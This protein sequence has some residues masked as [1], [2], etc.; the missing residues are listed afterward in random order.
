MANPI[1][2]IASRSCA[3]NSMLK[4]TG[5]T[6]DEKDLSKGRE[7][8]QVSTTADVPQDI[9][10]GRAA[11]GTQTDTTI[12]KPGSEGKPGSKLPSYKEAWEKD[13]EGIKSKYAS[14]EDYVKDMQGIKPGDARDVEREAA[15]AEAA[16]GTPGTPPTET[17]TSD[18]EIEQEQVKGQ[19]NL[20]LRADIRQ[21]KI[22][23]RLE[24]QAERRED[25][26]QRKGLSGKEKRALRKQQRKDRKAS[27]IQRQ[28]NIQNLIADRRALRD[29]QR[30]QGSFGGETYYVSKTRENEQG[31]IDRVVKQPNDPSK[32]SQTLTGKTQFTSNLNMDDLSIKA[33]DLMTGIKGI[34][35]TGNPGPLK[36]N[37]FNK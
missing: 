18:F 1:T 13:L 20:D 4:Q 2:A 28:Q 3:K 22:L 21:E 10:G 37:Y 11:Y 15:R 6:D 14:Y 27:N 26:F 23:N 9:G 8:K 24:R 33:P 35:K 19:E 34:L 36:K 16:K 29:L 17:K 7:T 30:D 25:R 32:T 31:Q 12:T 5:S